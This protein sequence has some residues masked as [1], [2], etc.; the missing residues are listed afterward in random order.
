MGRACPC[1]IPAHAVALIRVSRTLGEFPVDDEGAIIRP[2][3]ARGRFQAI[4]RARSSP[5]TACEPFI[6]QFRWEGQPCPASRAFSLSTPPHITARAFV[7]DETSAQRRPLIFLSQRRGDHRQRRRSCGA[8][9]QTVARPAI[10]RASYD[11][12]MQD[13]TG[14]VERKA[15]E[16]GRMPAHP[17]GIVEPARP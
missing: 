5:N 10:K 2:A 11:R 7:F 6:S 12:E 4:A 3:G 1:N 13:G 17:V 15:Q 9:D 16:Q 14:H 8:K